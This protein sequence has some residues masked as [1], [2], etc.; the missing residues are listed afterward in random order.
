MNTHEDFTEEELA[1]LFAC[2][3]A[4]FKDNRLRAGS[5]N[6]SFLTDIFGLSRADS[7]VVVRLWREAG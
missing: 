7:S 2:L 5:V 1:P 4:V 3:T 6:N